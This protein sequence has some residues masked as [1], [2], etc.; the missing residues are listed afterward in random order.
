MIDLIREFPYL[1]FLL[2]L[3]IVLAFTS[4]VNT[5]INRNKPQRNNE[6]ACC[7]DLCDECHP[8]E[9]CRSE[10]VASG[11]ETDEAK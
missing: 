2:L 6:E 4:V 3:V 7:D 10:V 9:S 11:S 1:S 8:E 5:F